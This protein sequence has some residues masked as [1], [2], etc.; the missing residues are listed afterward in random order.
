MNLARNHC[1]DC[2]KP[3]LNVIMFE[4]QPGLFRCPMC[5]KEIDHGQYWRTTPQNQRSAFGAPGKSGGGH[6]PVRTGLPSGTWRK[7]TSIKPIPAPIYSAQR[8]HADLMA[9]MQAKMDQLMYQTIL[10]S[11]P[12]AGPPQFSGFHSAFNEPT[13]RPELHREMQV[14]EIVGYRCWRYKVGLLQSVF[15]DDIWK[16]KQIMEGRGLEDWNK[17]GIHAWKGQGSPHY[18]QYCQST[19][20][21]CL[22]VGS[23]Y[24]WGDVVEH[25]HGYRGEFATV[26]SL[27]WIYFDVPQ[28]GREQIVLDELR[29]LYNV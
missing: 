2:S 26:R 27:D 6:T 29:K 1:P 5:K 13:P 18:Q 12:N 15:Q 4:I 28:M 19:H 10:Y 11:N 9:L 21:N 17:R 14:E 3:K 23:I 16:P 8:A 24:L 25:E 7:I 20:T 22:I